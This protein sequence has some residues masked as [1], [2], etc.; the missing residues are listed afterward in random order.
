MIVTGRSVAHAF[1]ALYYLEKACQH[2]VLAYST[3]RKLQPIPANLAAAVAD[4]W[5]AYDG[6][7]EAHFAELKALLEAEDAS[8]AT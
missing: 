5:E 2:L 1:D 8:Y 3:G 7:A 4:D 6:F